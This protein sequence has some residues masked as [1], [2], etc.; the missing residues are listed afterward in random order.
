M[1]LC[2][3]IKRRLYML[4]TLEIRKKKKKATRNKNTKI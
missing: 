4:E 2:K 3:L 1:D